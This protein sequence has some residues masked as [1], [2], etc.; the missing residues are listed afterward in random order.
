MGDPHKRKKARSASCTT[1][2]DY[3]IRILLPIPYKLFDIIRVTDA[4]IFRN[5][6]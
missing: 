1:G 5:G 3:Q 4:I 6:G 2:L